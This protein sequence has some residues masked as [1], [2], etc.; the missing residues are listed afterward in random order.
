MNKWLAANG[1]PRMPGVD[2]IDWIEAI[3][4][5][6][7]RGYVQRVLENAVVYDA[8][9][10]ARARMPERNR[11]RPI[12]ARR[13]ARAEL[14]LSRAARITSRPPGCA[15]LRARYD[16]LFGDERPKLVEIDLLGGGQWRPLGE[17]RLYLRPQ[18]AARDRPRAGLSREADEGG[19]GR[20]SRRAARPANVC[21]G[22]T[23]TIV[24]EDDNAA[25]SP[26]SATTRRMR[27]RP[28]RLALAARPGAEG[29]GGRRRAP[30]DAAR[31]A[32]RNRR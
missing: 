12:S 23:V 1:D 6:E 32:R 26:W 15:A 27:R 13:H 29:R 25:P 7:T 18:A 16:A 22:A 31:P 10:P 3:P 4:L 17:R 8:M 5:T 21:F 30:G 19:E 28:D 11:L 24:D 2:V 14:R 9:N 20:R